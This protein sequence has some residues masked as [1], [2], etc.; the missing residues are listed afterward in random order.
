MTLST[1]ANTME[2]RLSGAGNRTETVEG[3]KV[4]EFFVHH[5]VSGTDALRK[6]WRVSHYRSG[7]SLGTDFSKL[8]DA[9]G[10]ANDMNAN[11]QGDCEP[12]QLIDQF[13]ARGTKPSVCDLGEKWHMSYSL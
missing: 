6:M 3:K 11:Y 12:Q 10:F 7:M 13:Y 8:L 9:V 4:G 2:L 1:R 5:P